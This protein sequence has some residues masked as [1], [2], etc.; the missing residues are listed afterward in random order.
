[1][2]SECQNYYCYGLDYFFE[3]VDIVKYDVK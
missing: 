3:T 2:C 1:V